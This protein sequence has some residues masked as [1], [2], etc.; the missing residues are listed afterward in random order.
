M[1]KGSLPRPVNKGTFDA[2]F[3]KIFRKERAPAEKPL[4]CCEVK[5]RRIQLL[6]EEL[7]MRDENRKCQNCGVW[8]DGGEPHKDSCKYYRLDAKIVRDQKGIPRC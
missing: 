4:S 7:D 8:M 2:N 1:G 6:M 3:D 5:D